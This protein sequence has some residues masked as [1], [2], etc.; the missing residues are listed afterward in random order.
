M[1]VINILQLL[2]TFANITNII[3]IVVC[4]YSINEILEYFT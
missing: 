4:R 1:H 2:Y 3:L